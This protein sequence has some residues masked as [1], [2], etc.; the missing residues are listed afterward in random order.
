V[1]SEELSLLLK[2]RHM[3]TIVNPPEKSWLSPAKQQRFWD[4]KE[5][6]ILSA[7]HVVGYKLRRATEV[8]DFVQEIRLSLSCKMM[9][10]E[11]PFYEGRTAEWAADQVKPFSLAFAAAREVAWEP[12]KQLDDVDMNHQATTLD[13][14][15]LSSDAS[16]ASQRARDRVRTIKNQV[17]DEE[18][19]ALAKGAELTQDEFFSLCETNDIPEKKVKAY[20]NSSSP[21]SIRVKRCRARGRLLAGMAFLLVLLHCG[22]SRGADLGAGGYTRG[23]DSVRPYAVLAEQMEN[24][25]P[26]LAFGPVPG[27]GEV[28]G[29]ET[30]FVSDYMQN[31]ARALPQ[32]LYRAMQNG[33]RARGRALPATPVLRNTAQSPMGPTL[34]VRIMQN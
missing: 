13:A 6:E 19:I 10:G 21:T 23:I 16:A 20:M 4:L 8:K 25:L 30:I 33:A 34:F 32:G 24:R 29:W 14:I 7:A 26:P 11:W 15:R 5:A 22:K 18:F 9:A 12:L 2:E 17:T 3:D 31:R 1:I 27:T 28:V